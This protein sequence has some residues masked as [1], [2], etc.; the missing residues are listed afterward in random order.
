MILVLLAI[1]STKPCNPPPCEGLDDAACAKKATWVMVGR[2]TN[3]VRHPTG[4]PTFKDFAE[5]TF[6]PSRW[7]K[8]SGPKELKFRVG[9]CH[10]MREVPN[11]ATGEFR[12]FV[13]REDQYLDFREVR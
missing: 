11:P 10:N 12:F 6:V 9:W 13:G 5:F 8:G 7:E 4:E 2:I 3:V 1:L